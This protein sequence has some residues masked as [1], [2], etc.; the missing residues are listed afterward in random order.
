MVGR[1]IYDAFDFDT[2]F[3]L[4]LFSHFFLLWHFFHVFSST[5]TAFVN[6]VCKGL[7]P[8]LDGCP[9]NMKTLIMQCWDSEASGRPCKLIC[10]QSFCSILLCSFVCVSF[11]QHLKPLSREWKNSSN[12]FFPRFFSCTFNY[13]F[14]WWENVKEFGGIGMNE[15]KVSCSHYQWWLSVFPQSDELRRWLSMFPKFKLARSSVVMVVFV[16]NASSNAE[17]PSSWALLS[18]FHSWNQKFSLVISNLKQTT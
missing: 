5:S 2:Q 6:A 8:S 3:C 14:H 16:F 9:A 7:R 18:V 11:K 12:L 15:C 4:S 17:F 10:F 13:Q 1:L